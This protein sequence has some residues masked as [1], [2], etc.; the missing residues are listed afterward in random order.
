MPDSTFN[1]PTTR[2]E[3]LKQSASGLGLVAFSSVAPAF[4]TQSV[5]ASVPDAEKDRTILVLIQL[6]GGNDGLNTLVPFEDDNYYRLRP[7]L[8]LRKDELHPVTDQLGFHPAC[9]EMAELYREGKLAIVQNVG[10]PNPNR[11]HFRS[12]EIWETAS[13]SDEYLTTGWMG[14]YFDNCC[15]GIPT[16]DPLGLNIGNELPDIFLSGREHNIFSLANT[17][18]GKRTTGEGM[19]EA[20]AK[21]DFSMSENANFL[22]HT[23]MNALVT[24]SNVLKRLRGYQ[25]MAAY[26]ANALGRNLRDVAALIASGQ[27][28]RVYF[29]SLGGFDTHAN[30]LFRHRQLMEQLSSAMAAF[31]ADL[32]AHKL[33]DQVL[34][35]TFSE[36]GRRP[37]E[38][39]SGGT[40]HGTAAPLFVMGS[41]LKGSLFGQAPDLQVAKNKDLPFSTDFRSVYSTIIE[42]WFETDPTRVLEKKHPL[43]DFI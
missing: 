29:V 36:F 33:D 14:R 31:Q 40:D 6:A 21:G 15:A 13:G 41:K 9:G 11:S 43:I 26:P 4:L 38:N 5:R 30:Q 42:R 35:M 27:E 16:P 22:Q 23:L 17:G 8:G 28:T 1:Y 10:Y 20:I 32:A 3:F 34:T 37:S 19:K 2:R 7:K 12:M 24:E 18:R 25:P 39:V